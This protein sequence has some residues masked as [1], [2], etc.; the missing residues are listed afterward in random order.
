MRFQRR[1]VFKMSDIVQ[2]RAINYD[3]LMQDVEKI[4]SI[5]SRGYDIICPEPKGV[6]NGFHE[7]YKQKV[8]FEKTKQ[9]KNVYSYVHSSCGFHGR[10]IIS[11]YIVDSIFD[12]IYDAVTYK[13]R[14]C[15]DWLPKKFSFKRDNARKI[16]EFHS[17]VLYIISPMSLKVKNYPKLENALSNLRNRVEPNEIAVA[18]K[19]FDYMNVILDSINTSNTDLEERIDAV[20]EHIGEAEISL[21]NIVED[22]TF[23]IS[24]LF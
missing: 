1:G 22:M 3:E 12:A 2:E 19:H 21:A 20:K 6:C 8:K 17:Y 16:Q 7:W 4:R 9:Y 10:K 18:L 11:C 23:D 14:K 24:T 13:E 15:D 5:I